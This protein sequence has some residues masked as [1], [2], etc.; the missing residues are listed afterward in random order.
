MELALR[1]AYSEIRVHRTSTGRLKSISFASKYKSDAATFDD[2]A[3]FL[4]AGYKGIDEAKAKRIGP[5]VNRVIV[6]LSRLTKEHAISVEIRSLNVLAA[7][8]PQLSNRNLGV[9]PQAI[10]DS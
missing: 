3:R 8:M 10:C 7:A 4:V 6:I 9:P 1:L 5:I 2:E